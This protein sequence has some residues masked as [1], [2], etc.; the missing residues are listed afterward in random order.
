MRST[1]TRGATSTHLGRALC[2]GAVDVVD[3]I[4]QIVKEASHRSLGV[5][6]APGT[7]EGFGVGDHRRDQGVPARELPDAPVRGGVERVCA[8]EEAG[9][10]DGVEERYHSSRCD[11]MERRSAPPVSRLPG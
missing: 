8:I 1:S 4:D 2:D 6:S 3:R 10:D 7:R 9:N 11:S 5:V